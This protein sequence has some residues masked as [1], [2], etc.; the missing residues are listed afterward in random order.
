[1]SAARG[2]E[3]LDVAFALTCGFFFEDLRVGDRVG[4]PGLTLTAGHAA[5]HQ[6]VAGDRLCLALDTELCRRVTGRTAQLA[7]PML[8][9]DAA[10][11]QSTL[12]TRRV[13]ANLSYQ[14]L[15][16]KRAPSI[17][18]T[19]TT[20]T[21]VV[22][23][24]RTRPRAGR[25][26]SGIAALRVTT[27]DQEARPV[28]DFV[29]CA[30]LPLRDPRDG[31]GNKGEFELPSSRLEAGTLAAAI[32]GWDLEAFRSAVPGPR[33]L[34]LRKG[35]TWA[36]DSADIVSCAPELARLSLNSA[37]VHHD[38][39]ATAQRRRLV[40]GG[41]TIGI[42]ASQATRALP[43][44]L[45]ILA[46]ESCSHTAPVYEGDALRSELTVERL[47]A[48]DQG[49]GLVN[50]RSRVRAQRYDGAES[51]EVLDWRFVVALA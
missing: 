26:P 21:E 29:R 3:G 20:T 42:A 39:D 30:L 37:A 35:A 1:M 44:I 12:L 36:I 51:A 32:A 46:W 25:A 9:C 38:R 45:T 10:I 49:G 40:Y 43:G 28:L 7:H 6:A 27:V 50:L 33:F 17:G 31:A 15:V 8:V 48:L 23:L 13:I 16:F 14:G 41:H 47:Q 4:A 24:R 11:G 5:V 2:A 34:E 19:L 22:A 18:D